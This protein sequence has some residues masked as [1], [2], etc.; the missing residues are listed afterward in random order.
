ME[1][2]GSLG[3]KTRFNLSYMRHTGKWCEVFEGLS[4]EE[5]LAKIRED[6]LFQP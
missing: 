3:G 4:L 5:C 1:Y 6:Q 2:T